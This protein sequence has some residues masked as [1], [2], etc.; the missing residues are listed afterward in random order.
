MTQLLIIGLDGATFDLIEPWANDLPNLA[1]L[2]RRGAWGRLRSTVP[3]VTFPAWTSFMTG[4]NPGQHGVFDFT[5]RVPG[6]YRVEF[7]NATH[8]RRPTLWR[9]LSDAGCHVGVMGVPATYPPEHLNGFQISGFDAPVAVGID[10]SFVHP[11]ELY[12]EVRRAVGEYRTTDFQEVRIGPG[13]HRAATRSLLDVL[14]VKQDIAAYLLQ[15]EPWDCFMV[16]FGEADTVSHHF[17]LYH[18]PASPRH[19]PAGAQEFGDAIRTVYRRLD[20]AVGALLALA[21]DAHVLIASD[22]G[23]GGAGDKAVYLNRRLAE[24]GLLHFQRQSITNVGAGAARRLA[25]RLPAGAQERLFRLAGPWA[26]ALES[27]NRFAGIDWAGTRAFSEEQN[28]CPGVWINRRDREPL[29]IVAPDAYEATRDAVIEALLTWRDPVTGQSVVAQARR[30]EAVYQGPFV[31]EASDVVVEL[32]LDAGYSYAVQGS[33][34]RPGPSLRVLA[35]HEYLGA[36]GSGM[37][38]THRPDGVLL[39]AGPQVRAG[40][41]LHS[42]NIIDAAPTALHLLGLSVPSYMD[43][44]V[45]VEA[46]TVDRPV[47]DIEM[48]LPDAASPASYSP[49]EEAIVAARLRALGYLEDE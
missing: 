3:P 28:T 21:P 18:D 25:L 9:I 17:W 8:R 43:G 29:G 35:P 14:A 47:V 44:R 45:L 5:R 46:L 23:F 1:G 26:G 20:E 2:M 38:G 39:L 30:R 22:H 19:D 16:L 10:R 15:K 42:A 34:G 11:P 6:T 41:V 33:G 32:A 48:S 37:N 49:A 36:K 27:R 40:I 31:S 24:C 12:D 7:V 4:V 13:W